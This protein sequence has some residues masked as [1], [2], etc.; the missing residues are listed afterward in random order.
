M[1]TSPVRRENRN[2]KIILVYSEEDELLSPQ[3]TNVFYDLL[4]EVWRRKP[5]RVTI[6]GKHDDVPHRPEV[7]D[8]VMGLLEEITKRWC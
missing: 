6:G 7:R 3:Q 1:K 2:E 4:C 5:E 8:V